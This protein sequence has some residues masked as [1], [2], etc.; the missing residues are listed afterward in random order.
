MGIELD[1][2]RADGGAT[3]NRWLMQFQADVLRVPV[4]VA[5]EREMTALGAAAL[6]GLAVGVFRSRDEVAA[7]LRP[8]ARYEPQLAPDEADRLV[9]KWR[10][11]V[12]KALT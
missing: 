6:A 12:Q 9:E 4:E 10:A 7:A 3:A 2:L 8:A 5:A 1:V 11:A